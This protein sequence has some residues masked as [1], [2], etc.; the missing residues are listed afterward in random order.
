KSFVRG[1]RDPGVRW[2]RESLAAI[3]GRPVDPM[4]SELYDEQ[5][6]ARIRDFQRDRRLPVDGIAGQV[7]QV[8]INTGLG[9]D[10]APRLKALWAGR[11]SC[12]LDAL[13][14][15]DAERR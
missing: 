11:R 2:L 5:L 15:S 8:A 10:H 7:T 6:E 14:K 4:G 13:R 1:M 12:V 3:E 9:D